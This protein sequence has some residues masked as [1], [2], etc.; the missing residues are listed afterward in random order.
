M[1]KGDLPHYVMFNLEYDSW[2]RQGKG[3]SSPVS[4]M[5]I[6]VLK[7][8]GAFSYPNIHPVREREALVDQDCPA[9]YNVRVPAELLYL[10]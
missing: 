6:G 7:E 2:V 4:E 8:C 1:F 3:S 5:L 10:V 9:N